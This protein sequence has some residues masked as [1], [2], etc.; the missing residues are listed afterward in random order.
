MN[1]RRITT[2]PGASS[3]DPSPPGFLGSPVGSPVYYGFVVVPQTYTDGWCL[4]SITDFEDPAGCT[5]GDAFVIAPDGGRAGL[6]WEVGS[7]SL[8]EILAPDSE[9]WGVYAIWF[10]GATRTVEDLVNNFRFVLPELKETY[11]RVRK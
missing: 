3:S 8:Q 6:V 5:S 11:A 4:G 9:R 1:G 10:P 7:D 2:D